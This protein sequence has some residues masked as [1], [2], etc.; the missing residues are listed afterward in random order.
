MQSF[1]FALFTVFEIQGYNLKNDKIKSKYVYLQC[2]IL[3]TRVVNIYHSAG[4][5]VEIESL[6]QMHGH[7]TVRPHRQNINYNFK[8]PHTV[9]C[10][11]QT[12]KYD[13]YM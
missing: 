10:C 2:F 1:R 11:S 6:N 3:S 4:T 7:D 13:P 5:K 9:C 8:L 12:C